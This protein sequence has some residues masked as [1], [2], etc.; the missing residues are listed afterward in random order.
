MEGK[1]KKGGEGGGGGGE[2]EDTLE[3]EEGEGDGDGF[4]VGAVWV[5]EWKVVDES[6][7]GQAMECSI[8]ILDAEVIDPMEKTKKDEKSQQ[9]FSVVESQTSPS[10]PMMTSDPP[11]PPPPSSPLPSSSSPSTPKSVS[12]L[13]PSTTSSSSTPTPSTELSPSDNLGWKPFACVYQSGQGDCMQ[14]RRKMKGNV[15]WGSGDVVGVEVDMEK[16]RV[17][18]MKNG[19]PQPVVV[20]NI[21]KRIVFAV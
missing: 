14:K 6:E 1:K 11:P 10:S 18:W 15:A 12:P 9:I 5:S 20:T 19:K 16:R 8:G 17:G 2:D 13:P 21:P 3:I 7:S 4:A